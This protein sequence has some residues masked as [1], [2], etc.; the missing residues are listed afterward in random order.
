MIILVNIDVCGGTSAQF[1]IFGLDD[2]KPT[3]RFTSV[4]TIIWNLPLSRDPDRIISGYTGFCLL[5]S[6]YPTPNTSHLVV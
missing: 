6:R 3:V 5:K 4:S 1:L 2:S